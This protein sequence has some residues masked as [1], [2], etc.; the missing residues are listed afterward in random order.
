MEIDTAAPVVTRDEIRI[1]D[2]AEADGP[3]GPG[4]GIVAVQVG[5]LE[6]REDGALENLTPRGEST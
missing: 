3:L 4:H 6:P 1:I 2:A 5:T